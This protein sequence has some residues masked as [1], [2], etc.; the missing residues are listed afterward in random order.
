MEC[1]TPLRITTSCIYIFPCLLFVTVIVIFICVFLS[2][3]R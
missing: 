1:W 3:L 2:V